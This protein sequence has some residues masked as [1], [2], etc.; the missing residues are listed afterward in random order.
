MFR[1][2]SRDQDLPSFLVKKIP[3]DLRRSKPQIFAEISI[4]NLRKEGMRKSELFYKIS[5][6][7]NLKS[8]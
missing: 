1:I 2:H 5:Y 7:G 3:A 8:A 4:R 6:L